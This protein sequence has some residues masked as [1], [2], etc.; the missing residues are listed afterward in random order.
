MPVI[1][2]LIRSHY[3]RITPHFSNEVLASED[4]CAE[5]RL[6]LLADVASEFESDADR[7]LCVYVAQCGFF[8]QVVSREFVQFVQDMVEFGVRDLNL[9]HCPGIEPRSE[10]S[11]DLTPVTA[12]LRHDTYFYSMQLADVINKEIVLHVANIMRHNT[13]VRSVALA[14]LDASKY[15]TLFG[16]MLSSNTAH[17]IQALSVARSK[18]PNEGIW[19]LARALESFTHRLRV[20]RLAGCQLSGRRAEM[21]VSAFERNYGMSLGIEVLDLSDNRFDDEGSKAL[22]RW[23][24]NAKEH[25]RLRVLKLANANLN[26]TSVARSFRSLRSLEVLDISGNRV[27]LGASQLLGV[28][29]DETRALRRL[30]VSECELKIE[31]VQSVVLGLVS[32]ANLSEVHIDIANNPIHSKDMPLLAAALRK[33]TNLH[34]LDVG[35]LKLKPDALIVLLK[36]LVRAQTLDTLVLDRA[37]A[38]AEH[39]KVGKSL[40][41]LLRHVPSIKA[42]SVRG[43]FTKVLPDLLYGLASNDTLIELDVAENQ[44]GDAGAATLAAM[45]RCNRALQLLVCDRNDIALPGWASIRL[46]LQRCFNRSLVCL[47][48]PWIDLGR[49]AASSSSDTAGVA[50]LQKLRDILADIQAAVAT[51]TP[52]TGERLYVLPRHHHARGS[53]YDD[54]TAISAAAA[55]ATMTTTAT[56]TTPSIASYLAID[57]SPLAD[58]TSPLA[59][60]P[61]P[62]IELPE[63]IARLQDEARART[64]VVA[65]ADTATAVAT[66]QQQQQQS[67][68]AP[69][70]LD[71]PNRPLPTPPT[72]AQR[73]SPTSTTAFVVPARPP[74]PTP[75]AVAAV[76]ASAAQQQQ[77]TPPHLGATAAYQDYAQPPIP[78]AS[79]M[80]PWTMQQA[81]SYYPQAQQ[82]PP[83]PAR[84]PPLP[85]RPDE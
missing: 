31:L 41:A 58:L 9:A 30:K 6:G 68:S 34:T 69:P 20:L 1:L 48:F 72:A 42:L 43:G 56:T 79:F 44:I 23:L 53:G 63:H 5:S 28:T 73:N 75:Q 17:G 84:A 8:R 11:F 52:T 36:A 24:H 71:V 55:A 38:G 67:S 76:R 22:E 70:P 37:Y 54:T 15:M 77:F 10:I 82:P 25:S 62:L 32:N 27:D 51:N 57:D 14:N 16:D 40:A 18:I 19:S 47:P 66:I 7:L 85:P 61:E 50:K 35:G 78:A 74:P 80:P 45:L 83:S 3:R 33:S 81:P 21:L 2:Q 49:F 4:L 26:M 39:P 29:I 12:A 13:S 60:T 59:A 46:S 64:L 65:T